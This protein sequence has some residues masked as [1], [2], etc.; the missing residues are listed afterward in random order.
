MTYDT[1]KK[2]FY[3]STKWNICMRES[4][5]VAK[6]MIMVKKNVN[7]KFMRAHSKITID[8]VKEN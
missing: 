3:I 1:Q 5:F 4:L 8:M 2:A 6:S 7:S